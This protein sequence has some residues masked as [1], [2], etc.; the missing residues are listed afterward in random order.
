MSTTPAKLSRRVPR[1]ERGERRMAEI[2]DAGAQ[3]I[4]S[5]GYEGATMTAIAERAQASIGTVYE[6]FPNKEAL[7]KALIA[8]YGTEIEER[9]RHLDGRAK[10]LGIDQLAEQIVDITVQ[11]MNER[12]AYIPLVSA[13][14]NYRRDPAA[15][16]RLR[17]RL[18]SF[19]MAKCPALSDPAALRTANIMVQT[20]KGLNRLY[21][22]A[23]PKDRSELVTEYKQLLRS[24]LRDRLA[25]N[26]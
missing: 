5:C 10:H 16:H 2:L 18:A 24:Y 20:V 4:A 15:R 17:E 7:A 21:G 11:F 12:P 19:L 6:Y 9:W 22:E 26:D 23:R 3:E 1:Q 8:Q 13:Q 14:I 25:C